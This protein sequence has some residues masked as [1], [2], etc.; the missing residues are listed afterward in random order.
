VSPE[1]V[2]SPASGAEVIPGGLL[3]FSAAIISIIFLI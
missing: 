2:G 1:I 3:N